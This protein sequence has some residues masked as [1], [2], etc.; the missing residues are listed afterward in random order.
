MLTPKD[1]D[2]MQFRATRLKEGYDQEEVD[3][4][5]DRVAADYALALND[6][7][8]AQ[9]QVASLKRRN[10]ALTNQPTEALDDCALQVFVEQ[11]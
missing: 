2:E 8:K 5:L 4:F 10:E 3:S 7:A 9:D 11:N 6:L 1:I